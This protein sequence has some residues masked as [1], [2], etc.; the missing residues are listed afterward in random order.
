MQEN[1]WKIT[2]I[3]TTKWANNFAELLKKEAGRTYF[4]QGKWGSGKTEYIKKVEEL[5]KGN[6]K[7]VYLKLWKPKDNKSLVRQ[8]FS[9]V[10][11]GPSCF[12]TIFFRV[13]VITMIGG[14]VWLA[15]KDLFP[16][17]T[18]RFLPGVLPAT[19][20]ATIITTLFNLAN[21][22]VINV[23]EILLRFS[24]NALRCESNPALVLV[25]D[26]FDRIDPK[27]QKELYKLFNAIQE[28]PERA[29]II[30]IGDYDNIQKN[31]DNYLSKIIDQ[32]IALPIVL[33]A[34]SVA[35]RLEETIS[36]NLN[37][38]ISGSEIKELFID[39]NRTL[40]DAN[41]F[42]DYAKREFCDHKKK[43][44]VQTDQQLYIIYLY[45]FHKKHYK[46]LIEDWL[47]NK[48]NA[49]KEDKIDRR[50][51]TVL[52]SDI[53]Y[54]KEYR[55]NQPAY[56]INELATNHSISELID[57]VENKTTELEKITFSE[58]NDSD[59]YYSELRQFLKPF[60]YDGSTSDYFKE[61]ESQLCK[62]AF[63]AMNAEPRH[64][65]NELIKDIL[66]KS[67]NTNIIE[68]PDYSG[69]KKEKNQLKLAFKNANNSFK[70]IY[71]EASPE[72]SFTKLIYIYRTCFPIMGIPN[73][74]DVIHGGAEF[75][76]I[77][78]YT[79]TEFYSEKAE[80]I[81]NE[82][83]FG[84]QTYDAEALLVLLCFNPYKTDGELELYNV[85]HLDVKS[86]VDKIEQLRDTEYIAF[87][88]AYFEEVP[89]NDVAEFL[90][91]P[92]KGQNYADWMHDRCF[93]IKRRIFYCFG[94][95]DATKLGHF[96]KS[97]KWIYFVLRIID[98]V[99]LNE[100]EYTGNEGYE[101]YLYK[102]LRG[103]IN[104][105]IKDYNGNSEK[106]QL[107]EIKDMLHAE[108]ENMELEVLTDLLNK[109]ESDPNWTSKL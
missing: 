52:N 9:A 28:K 70:K 47:K 20:I 88:D 31:K 17:G 102:C 101:E 100:Q 80:E 79:L 107:L 33:S 91:F 69:S 73:I 3:E 48:N 45:L 7:F 57:F 46:Q 49:H 72:T 25:I 93:Q 30:F 26:D 39:E 36:K 90:K 54:P 63:F 108:N 16:E 53:K 41:Q 56:F 37:E 86:K 78:R 68:N 92:Y 11:P 43:G 109:V 38:N 50:T 96:L 77:N 82:E 103:E 15:L 85:E 32:I 98:T 6:L 60:A 12:L 24:L 13:V 64:K 8:L 76:S 65:P 106:K 99:R 83:N 66:E 23:D 55:R 14:S 71:K 1:N 75:D 87:W 18:Q 19:I 10:F 5:T 35:S 2:T 94:S 89:D 29:R 74:H 95:E 59:N 62:A 58:K 42:L 4:L 105:L 34:G 21:N 97:E 44:R 40:R 84:Q 81:V 61:M 27:M 22:K 67:T 51:G 104:K